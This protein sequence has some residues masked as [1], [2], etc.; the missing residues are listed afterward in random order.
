VSENPICKLMK[1]HFTFEVK[2]LPE[3]IQE[4]LLELK[5]DTTAQDNFHHLTGSNFE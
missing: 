1:N 5:F 2:F 4:E 3:A